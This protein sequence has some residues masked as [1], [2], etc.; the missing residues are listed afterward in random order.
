MLDAGCH[1]MTELLAHIRDGV[2]FGSL[3]A[4][5]A[6]GYTMVYGVL[7][8]INFAHGDV[9]MVAA[10]AGFFAATFVGFDAQPSAPKVVL[11]VGFAVVAS[12]FLGL[13][14]ERLAYRPLR[15]ASRLT[16]LITAIG[17]SLLLENGGQLLWTSTPRSF[18]ALIPPSE[19][20]S[21]IVMLVAMGLAFGLDMFVKRTRMG[22]AM[23]AVAQDKDAAALMGIPV[24][25]VIS[26][27]FALGS[28][29]AAAAAML[30]ASVN[31]SINPMM[32]LL[33][34]LKAFVAAV[35]GGIGSLPGALLGGLVLGV[36]EELISASALSSYRDAIAFALLILILVFRPAGL[37]GRGVVEK[38]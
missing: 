29:L 21:Y 34:G 6:L 19:S 27:T 26:F 30:Y 37:L 11:I 9:F 24:D 36:S 32:G 33:L 7:R 31:P 17:V 12:V 25:R 15:K 1:S 14:I 38:V 4:L 28:A 18:P 3:Y 13:T 22:R 10:Y 2:M 5:I 35:I 23:R 8:L 16:A 20:R